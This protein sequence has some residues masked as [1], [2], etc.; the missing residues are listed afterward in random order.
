MLAQNVVHATTNLKK[1]FENIKSLLKPG[2]KLLLQEGVRQDFG[3]STIA[4]GQLPGWWA[5]IEP[6]RRLS[7]WIASNEWNEIIK[8]SGF[9]G[10]DL[11]LPDRQPADLHTQSLFVATASED[12]RE[13][14]QWPEV[15]IVTTSSPPSELCQSLKALLEQKFKVSKCNIVHYLDLAKTTLDR[16]VCISFCELERSLL[17][18]LAQDEFDNI[19]QMLCICKG[20]IWITGDTEK[21]PEFA[22]MTGLTRTVRW[23]RDVDDANLVNLAVAEQGQSLETIVSSIG[24]LF[25]QQFGGSLAPE[26]ANGEFIL[27]DGVF[28]TSRLVEAKAA[29]TYLN[30]QFSRAK[31][32]MM[33]LKDAGRPIKLATSAPGLL[34]RL[35]WVTDE[36][37]NEPLADTHLEIDIKAVGM[38]FRDLMIAMGEHMAYSMGNEAAGTVSRIGSK[39]ADFKVGDRVVYLCG[40][41]S[42]G[43]FHTFGRVDQNVVV[44]IPEHMSYE[45]ACGLPCVYATVIYG[46]VDAGR[47]EQGEK[48]LIHA[49]AGGVGQ[50]AIHFAKYI[51]AEIFATVSSPEKKKLIMKLGVKEEN[52]FSSRDLTFVKGIMHA[53]E[54]N[55]VDLV[56][57]SLSGEAL[58]RSWDLLA[59]FGR[60]IEIGKKDAQN[61]GKVEL[62]P[63]LRNVTMASVELPTMMRHRPSLIKRLTEDTVRLW[64]EGHVKEADPMTIMN[65]SQ[66]EEGLRILQ[67]GKGMGKMI[68]V[69][70]PDDVLPIVPSKSPVYCLRE[71]AVYLM[72]GGLGGIGR[73]FARW[74]AK[75]GA[76]QLLFFSSTGAITS[77]VEEMMNDLDLDG[78]KVKILKCDVSDKARLTAVLEECAATLPPI[79]GVVQGAMKLKVWCPPPSLILTS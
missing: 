22:M 29:D 59:P 34:D 77:A 42:T 69:P 26:K 44:K 66:V 36:I 7:P 5:G 24:E 41:E 45:V 21:H 11:E 54:G 62:R 76:R 65:F 8:S 79:K 10:I 49:A 63:F 12:S 57:N 52:I 43:C 16:V 55:G 40:I 72:A 60:F 15:A 38:N 68:F 6:A 28:L 23:E 35:E 67:S 64:I 9:R 17:R 47:L 31:P 70:T 32:T 30:T 27:R 2:G 19:R 74:M 39:V 61:N 48:I 56:L 58:R 78:C 3:W 71:D 53:T 14:T 20:M 25:K 46:L 37:Y 13:D 33:A 51:G 18:D 50:A 4:F 75:H 73:S 1:T